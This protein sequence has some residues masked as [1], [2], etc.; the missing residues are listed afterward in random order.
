MI[1]IKAILSQC[2]TQFFNTYILKIYNTTYCKIIILSG[3]F[4]IYLCNGIHGWFFRTI[5]I[6]NY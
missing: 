5:M 4:Y 1:M 6:T 2:I 3:V